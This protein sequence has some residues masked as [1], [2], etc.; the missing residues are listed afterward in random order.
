MNVRNGTRA[1]AAAALTCLAVALLAR[2][3]LPVPVH[4]A[5]RPPKLAYEITKLPNGLTVIMS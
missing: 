4:G 3:V 5:V 2:S 1:A